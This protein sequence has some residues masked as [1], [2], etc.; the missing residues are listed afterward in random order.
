[1]LNETAK[2]RLS[3]YTVRELIR[4]TPESRIEKVFCTLDE[5]LYIKRIYPADKRE[6]FHALQESENRYIPTIKEIIFDDD[7]TVIEEFISGKR[8]SELLEKAALSKKQVFKLAVQIFDALRMLHARKIIHRDIKPDN[9]IVD[10][11]GNAWLI[12]FGIAR[13]Y[14][15]TAPHDTQHFGTI[16][17]APP[18]QYGFAQTNFRSDIYA[19]G[20]TIMEAGKAAKCSP[21]SSLMRVAAKCAEFDPKRRCSSAVE[22]LR[23]LRRWNRLPKLAAVCAIGAMA[24]LLSIYTFNPRQSTIVENTPVPSLAAID[25]KETERPTDINEST[26]SPQP[27]NPKSTPEPPPESDAASSPDIELGASDADNTVEADMPVL[28]EIYE[29]PI[30]DIY[31]EHDYDYFMYP[32]DSA[33]GEENIILGNDSIVISY[34]YELTEGVLTLTLDDHQLPEKEFIFSYEPDFPLDYGGSDTQT[35]AE[36]VLFDMSGDGQY[37]ILVALSDRFTQRAGTLDLP[38]IA[39]NWTTVWCIGYTA[40]EGFWLAEGIVESPIPRLDY[41]GA[42]ELYSSD[43]SSNPAYTCLEGRMLI[44]KSY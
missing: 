35:D 4:E 40:G 14:D 7:T 23:L 13:F 11:S 36:I 16:G 28:G 21:R 27:Q 10:A 5:Q 33:G 6:L 31:T 38:Y 26:A 1:M 3:V 22:A 24:A 9:I 42:R 37:E 32:A 41:L 30:I 43:R 19:A 8:L 17:Y 25:V 20:V 39:V 2:Y 29:Y 12:D 18:E 44:E 34:R 15:E